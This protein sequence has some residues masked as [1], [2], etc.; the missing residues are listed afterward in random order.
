[1]RKVLSITVGKEFLDKPSVS[2]KFAQAL[3]DPQDA[4]ESIAGKVALLLFPELFPKQRTV[5]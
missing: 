1:M 2:A 3:Q 5:A 4:P